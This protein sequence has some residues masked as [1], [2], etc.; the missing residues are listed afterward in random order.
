MRQSILLQL[1][2]C[3]IF[4]LTLMMVNVLIDVI[5]DERYQYLFSISCFDYGFKVFVEPQEAEGGVR[6]H[7][8]IMQDWSYKTA[9]T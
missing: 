9:T 6:P 7:K 4:R 1:I 5:Y 3:F 2:F 8:H